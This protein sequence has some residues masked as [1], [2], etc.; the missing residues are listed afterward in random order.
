VT[1]RANPGVRIEGKYKK[2]KVEGGLD[3]VGSKD[4]KIIINNTFLFYIYSHLDISKFR[5]LM[6]NVFLFFCLQ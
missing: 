3:F 4:S 6:R 2:I 5:G 1:L